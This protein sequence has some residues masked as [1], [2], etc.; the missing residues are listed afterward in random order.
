MSFEEGARVELMHRADIE[1]IMPEGLGFAHL[2][3]QVGDES[4][5]RQAGS[6]I[7]RTRF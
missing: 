4:R 3:L 5:G 6:R 7:F 1:K 2:A